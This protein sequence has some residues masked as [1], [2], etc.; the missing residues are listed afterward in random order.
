LAVA[1]HQCGDGS[2]PEAGDSTRAIRAALLRLLLLG[3]EGAPPYDTDS[4]G[5]RS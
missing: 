4:S 1:R 5:D 3:A 2:L